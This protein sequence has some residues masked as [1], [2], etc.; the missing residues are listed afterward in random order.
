MAPILAIAL[1]A[2][3]GSSPGASTDDGNGGQSAAAS[4]EASAAESDAGPGASN[5]G[6]SGSDLEQVAQRLVPPNSSETSKTT[7]SGV[8]FVTYDSSD[9]PDT[10]KSFYENAISQLGWY[11]FSTTSAGGAYSWIIGETEAGDAAGSITVG[12]GANDGSSS[13]LIQL[14]TGN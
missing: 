11:T 12:P 7:A 5:G 9:S 10:L 3:G 6:L 4:A 13:V 8:I 1:A 2:C 14:G